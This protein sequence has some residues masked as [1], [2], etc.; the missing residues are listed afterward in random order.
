MI[1]KHLSNIQMICKMFI[2]NLNEYN[3][4]KKRKM[5]MVFDD[6]IADMINNKRRNLIVTRWRYFSWQEI[7]YLSCF[8]YTIIF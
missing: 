8:Y 6:M 5:L 1:Q 7:K 2:K 4:D 3:I